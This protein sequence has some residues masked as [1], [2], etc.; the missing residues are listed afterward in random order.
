MGQVG[1]GD[2]TYRG[3]VNGTM[4]R[5]E[6]GREGGWQ[7]MDKRGPARAPASL[8]AR[9][10]AQARCTTSAFGPTHS[11]SVTRPSPLIRAPHPNPPTPTQPT[12][13]T[14]QP[15]PVTHYPPTPP[16]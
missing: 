11:M 8:A 2:T 15:Q 14:P 3:D 1:Y 13:Q 16:G 10:G 7:W 6:G 9:Q 12:T 5:A 4:V